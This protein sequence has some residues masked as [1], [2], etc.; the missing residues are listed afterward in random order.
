MTLVCH[1]NGMLDRGNSD[2]FKWYF[3]WQ[4]SLNGILRK[5]SSFIAT[6]PIFRSRED[7][8]SCLKL[9]VLEGE[10]EV[11]ICSGG[12]TKAMEAD[13]RYVFF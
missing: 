2:V 4:T 11:S 6:E 3:T 12:D 9:R 13:I 8:S 1:H 7:Y 5:Q 10:A